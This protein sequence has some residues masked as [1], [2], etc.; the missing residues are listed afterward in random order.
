M[1]AEAE[2]LKD[3][4]ECIAM[5]S[6]RRNAAPAGGSSLVE[7]LNFPPQETKMGPGSEAWTPATAGTPG[8]SSRS[9]SAQG[10]LELKRGSKFASVPSRRR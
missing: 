2:V 1:E 10:W 7:R 6:R 5:S 8:E 4:P 9:T 3:D